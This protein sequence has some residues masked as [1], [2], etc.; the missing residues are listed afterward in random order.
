MKL[1]SRDVGAISSAAQ[2]ITPSIVCEPLMS[3][4][5]FILGIYALHIDGWDDMPNTRTQYLWD[6]PTIQ[7][8]LL[9]LVIHSPVDSHN[10]APAALTCVP[11]G[12]VNVLHPIQC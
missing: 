2:S 8:E 3:Y 6:V 7:S 9:T 5:H 11:P 12:E 1:V 10:T 4:V